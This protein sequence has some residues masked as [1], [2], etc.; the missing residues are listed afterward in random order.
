MAR[1]GAGTTIRVTVVACLIAI[2][3]CVVN[4]PTPAPAAGPME[5][6]TRAANSAAT[7][8]ACKARRRG[9]I[10]ATDRTMPRTIDRSNATIGPTNAT[11]DRSSAIVRSR[12]RKAMHGRSCRRRLASNRALSP[13][14]RT[15]PI[16]RGRACP[17]RI[18]QVPAICRVRIFLLRACRLRPPNRARIF[19][20]VWDKARW[21]AIPA[22]ADGIA[23]NAWRLRYARWPGRRLLLPLHGPRPRRPRRGLL[24]RNGLRAVAA[25]VVNAVAAMKASSA[26]TDP[27]S[28]SHS[29]RL[30]KGEVL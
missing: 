7:K 24:R 13:R 14:N 17:R 1:R 8:R 15:W 18:C 9:R 2:L 20:R 4:F 11:I 5:G 21:C 28:R 23:R 29:T 10:S 27:M 19:S 25:G 30:C 6:R 3:C 26:S 22:S 12:V 16:C